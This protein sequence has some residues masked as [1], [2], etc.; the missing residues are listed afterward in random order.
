MYQHLSELVHTT[1]RM[2]ILDQQLI[3]VLVCKTDLLPALATANGLLPPPGLVL[4]QLAANPQ[5]LLKCEGLMTWVRDRGRGSHRR[6]ISRLLRR[7]SSRWES[8]VCRP[9]PCLQW[10]NL[11]LDMVRHEATRPH[12]RLSTSRLPVFPGHFLLVHPA[13]QQVDMRRLK[14]STQGQVKT[15]KVTT[16]RLLIKVKHS[17]LDTK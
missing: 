13:R 16:R 14:G 7:I 11:G 3:M 10:A 2:L 4:V 12:L 6:A 9:D 8:A 5:A 1:F 15:A 17:K